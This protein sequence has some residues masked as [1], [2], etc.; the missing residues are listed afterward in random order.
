MYRECSPRLPNMLRLVSSFV[1][2]LSLCGPVFAQQTLAISGTVQDP[3]GAD[4]SG[5]VVQ[6]V[7]ADT[8]VATETTK[9]G[10]RYELQVPAGVP[11]RLVARFAGFADEVVESAGIQRAATRDLRL[12]VGRLADSMVVT[13]T[14]SLESQ[15]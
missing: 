3:S 8:V 12:Q 9:E 6:L 5:A 10:G 2:V 14:R 13:A 15:A 4:L 1:L 11:F 7:I